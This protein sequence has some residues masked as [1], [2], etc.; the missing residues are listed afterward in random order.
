MNTGEDVQGLR[1]I[2]DFTRLLSIFILAIHFYLSCY[3]AFQDWGWTAGITDKITGNIAETGLF[4]GFFRAKLAALLLLVISLIG[5]K[6]KKDEKITLKPIIIYLVVGAGLYFAS[7]LCFLLLSLLPGHKAIVSVLYIGLTCLGYLLMLAGGGQLSRLL[8][9]KLKEDIFNEESETFPQEERLLENEFSINLPAKYRLGKLVRESWI[10]IINPFRGLLVAGTPGAGKS[11]FVIRH[12]IDQHILKGFSMFIYDFKFDDLSR[13]AYNKLIKYAGNYKVRPK[14][15]VI[16]FDDLNRTHRC[17]PLDPQAMEDI[18]DATEASRTIMMGLNRDWIKKQ[19]DFFVESP[20]NFL[21]ACIWYLRR[22]EDGRFC[23]LP[24]V[25]ELM[26]SDYDPLFAVLK[27]QEEIKVLI[28]PFI[29]AYRN[30]AMA[31][32]EGQI[33]SAKIGLARLSSPQLY[34]VLSGSDFTLDVNCP[35][36]P[37][38]VCVGNNPQKLQVYGAVLSLYI[39]RMIKLVNQKG[40]LKSSLVFDEFPTIYFNN[41]DALIATARSNQVSTC[42]AVQDF[43]QLTK[44]YGS[45]QADVITG[46]VGNVISGQV[47]GDTA[48]QL[49]ENFGKISQRKD[50]MSINSSDTSI[51]RA[52]QMDYAIPASKIASLSAGEFV[53]VVADNPEQKIKLK[54][55]H[56]EIQNDHEAIASEESGYVGIPVVKRVSAEMVEENYKQIK[57][58]IFELLKTECAKQEVR[59]EVKESK[60]RGKSGTGK[61]EEKAQSF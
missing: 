58:E 10:N 19:G 26:Q 7:T 28:N 8:K 36:E 47:T 3:Q 11:Y 22:Y 15:F 41:M 52:T 43:S 33:A 48:K 42:L 61:G 2:I 6:G 27:T 24:H 30:N 12:I 21:T 34:Y 39:S 60:K 55:F 46:I 45:E 56:A 51:T 59:A 9:D 40:K 18:T 31:Q 57:R 50:S 32:L 49:S 29:S 35:E 5:V 17:N 54:M 13:I 16:N 14:F 1:K 23:T 44:D 53:G 20:I 25:I 4:E 37:K 38:I